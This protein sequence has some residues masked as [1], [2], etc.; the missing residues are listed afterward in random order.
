MCPCISSWLQDA[1]EE[2]PNKI[3]VEMDSL[4]EVDASGKEV[5]STATLHALKVVQEK[6]NS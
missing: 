2:E 1:G 5:G 4:T 3:E 6:G